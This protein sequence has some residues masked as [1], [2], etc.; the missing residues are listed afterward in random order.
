MRAPRVVALSAL[1]FAAFFAC[2]S[3]GAF[4]QSGVSA[5]PAERV[6]VVWRLVEERYWDLSTVPVAWDEVR[7]RYLDLARDARSAADVDALLVAMVDELADEHSRYVPTDEVRR[8]RDAFGD[9]PCVGVFSQAS[10]PSGR[11]GPVSWRL[12]DGLGIVDVD[13]LA[14]AGTAA[15]V[16]RAVERLEAAG[17]DALALDLRGNPGGRLIEMMQVAGV[18]VRGLLWRVATSWSFPL[19]YPAI[20]TP[21]SDLPLAVLVDAS[22]ASAAEG[23]AGALQ[24]SGRAT[25]IGETTSGNVEAVLPFCLRDGSQVWLATGVLAPLAGPT[26]EGRGV[27]PD[28]DVPAARAVRAAREALIPAR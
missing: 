16:R 6:D 19:P 10:G 7:G 12:E 26:W 22:V 25:V 13:D 1:V 24:T 20:G 15:G 11:E 8:V 21:A 27:A 3:G 28:I 23:L 14:R 4:A 2:S 5:E 17:A 9:L 18:F